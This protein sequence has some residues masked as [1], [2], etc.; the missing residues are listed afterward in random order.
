M[1]RALEI[2]SLEILKAAEKSSPLICLIEP[3]LPLRFELFFDGL[4]KPP[5]CDAIWRVE[6]FAAPMGGDS[7]D[8][9]RLRKMVSSGKTSTDRRSP[10]SAELASSIPPLC[11]IHFAESG[12]D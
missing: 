9:A 6:D 3:V 7:V 8:G 4:G 11:E 2:V 1:K 10:E 12:D 5:K